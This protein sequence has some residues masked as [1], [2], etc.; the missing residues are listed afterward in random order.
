[1]A[2]IF[3]ANI[4]DKV[5]AVDSFLTTVPDV[6]EAIYKLL[7]RYLSKFKTAD[8]KFDPSQA[9][10]QVI[11]TLKKELQVILAKTRFDKDINGFLDDFDVIAANVQKIH[12]ELNGLSIPKS[13]IAEQKAFAVESTIFSLK[14]ANINLKFID[15][16]KKLLYNRV[17]FGAGVLETEKALREI[18]IGDKDGG[19]LK[20][21]VGQVARDAINQYEGQ[22]NQRI[23]VQYELTAVRYVGPILEDSRPQCIRWVKMEIINDSDLE[24]EI[25]WAFKNGKG[26]I[27][28]TTPETFCVNCGGYNCIHSAFPTM[29]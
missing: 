2:D 16:I 1:M 7:V 17:N 27:P 29:P 19:I 9:P 28:S 20:R 25:K 14:D 3:A 26:M 24:K 12:S 23:K 10:A 4:D 21:W 13:L 11:N 6:E 18:I 22:I 8:G 15:P 5:A